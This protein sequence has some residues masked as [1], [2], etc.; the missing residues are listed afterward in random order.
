[1]A[2]NLFALVTNH[3]LDLSDACGEETIDLVVE[4]AVPFTQNQTFRPLAVNRPDSGTT[5]RCKN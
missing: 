1:M 3:D 4:N 5:S 2:Q